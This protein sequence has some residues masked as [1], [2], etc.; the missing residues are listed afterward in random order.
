MKNSVGWRARLGAL[1]TILTLA[2]TGLMLSGPSARAVV[3]QHGPRNYAGP[4]G[5]CPAD[6]NPCDEISGDVIVVQD[7]TNPDDGGGRYNKAVCAQSSTQTGA[8]ADVGLLC[9][10]TQ[11][12]AP[13]TVTV[14]MNGSASN[15]S[16]GNI[17]QAVALRLIVSQTGAFG[18]VVTGN[19]P[20]AGAT[21]TASE[22]ANPLITPMTNATHTQQS[23]VLASVRQIATGNANNAATLTLNR[24]Q[25]SSVTGVGVNQLQD[26]TVDPGATEGLCANPGRNGNACLFQ[27]SE[28]GTQTAK[29]RA[30]DNKSASALQVPVAG[31]VN[32]QQGPS[33]AIG[34][35]LTEVDMDS[36]G[37]PSGGTVDL[38]EPCVPGPAQQP[39]DGTTDCSTTPGVGKLWTL[40]AT[41]AVPGIQVAGNSSQN[42]GVLDNLI[43][44]SPCSGRA[45]GWTKL[46]TNRTGA[47]G[48]KQIARLDAVGHVK[49]DAGWTGSISAQLKDFGKRINFGGTTVSAHIG[50]DDTA[51][52]TAEGCQTLENISAYPT[53]VSAMRG[54]S[55]T[56]TMATF[57]ASGGA[58]DYSA[59]IDWD[60]NG[61]AA[62]EAGTVE[63]IPPAGNGANF[64]VVGTHTYPAAGTYKV[65]VVITRNNT[66]ISAT[67]ESTVN[68]SDVGC[69]TGGCF[70][71]GDL[72]GPNV[73]LWG[74][75]WAAANPVSGG[76]KSSSFK[77]W[78]NTV[79]DPQT[80]GGTNP[81]T[82]QTKTGN[83]PPPPGPSAIPDIM[84]V[85]VTSVVNGGNTPSGTI[86]RVVIVQVTN[87]STYNAS[88][89]GYLTGTIIGQRCP[90]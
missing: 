56:K 68:V 81:P 10:V 4:A 16:G 1:G 3:E 50:C 9:Q 34:G 22:T 29:I 23:F 11:S 18:N 44:K 55:F 51:N 38:G 86:V 26:V 8:S 30:R 82:W 24:S 43:G 65:P 39:P 49:C 13:N 60:G 45:T 2:V 17:S 63:A 67:V 72:A 70:V 21:L 46:D 19:D 6:A 27:R 41:S 54:V 66:D 75:Q 35:W 5:T 77:G 7:Q 48:T 90:V 52:G 31:V 74:S 32:Q 73:T 58:G 79:G 83:S 33:E 25:T 57:L 61:P 80:C 12:N 40:Q 87:K 37:N 59:T 62:P 42:D 88:P 76:N 14:N 15:G 71:I 28:N 89:S 84:P 53:T 85:L 64:R 47:N 78:E 20:N 36:S 69:P